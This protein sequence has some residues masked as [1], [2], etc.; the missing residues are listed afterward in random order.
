MI[1][2]VRAGA[3][4]WAPARTD[5]SDEPMRVPDP[6]IQ[7]LHELAAEFH[8]ALSDFE[9]EQYLP[10]V[11]A[12]VEGYAALDELGRDG[13]PRPMTYPATPRIGR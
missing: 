8:F 12:T 2:R 1:A 11:L 9:S 13:S 4:H 5:P 3:L 6:T 7:D 10:P